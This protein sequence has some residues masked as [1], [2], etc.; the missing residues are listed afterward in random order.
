VLSEIDAI[1]SQP[2]GQTFAAQRLRLITL[3]EGRWIFFAR[4]VLAWFVLPVSKTFW[5]LYID[6]R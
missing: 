1:C 3:R 5:L 6:S 2:R 4:L